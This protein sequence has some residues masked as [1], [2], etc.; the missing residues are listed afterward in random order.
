MNKISDVEIDVQRFSVQ[1][2]DGVG[3]VVGRADDLKLGC[4]F[5]VHSR[6][7]LAVAMAARG[8]AHSLTLWCPIRE[9]NWLSLIRILH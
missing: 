1:R 5:R 8:S 2:A 3:A 9:K 7:D 4:G 6:G